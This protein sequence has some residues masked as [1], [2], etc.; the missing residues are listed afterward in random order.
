M[1]L[2]VFGGFVLMIKSAVG[3]AYPICECK[4]GYVWLIISHADFGCER[5][6]IISFITLFV[7]H[8]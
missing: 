2:R 7:R 6:L 4:V 1:L 3:K 5:S 8:V